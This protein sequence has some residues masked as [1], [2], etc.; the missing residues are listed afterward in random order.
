MKILL[1]YPEYPD[2][3]WSFKY[4]LKFVAKKAAFPPL[5]LLT[6]AALLPDSWEKKL[7]D[8]NVEELRDEHI[9]WADLVFLGAMLVQSKSAAEIISRCRHFGKKIV[10]GGPLFTTQHQNYPDIDHF[11]LNEAE[12]TLPQ[13]LS[14]LA[15]G[16][17]RR[18]YTADLKPDITR[19][20][21][22]LWD[23][24]DMKNYAT[25]LIQ[26]SRG[27]PFNCE[28]C[29]I[30]IMNGRIPRTKTPEQLVLEFQS[31]YDAGWR[32]SVFIVDDNFIGNKMKVKQLLP[33]LADW[34]KKHRYPFTL[35]TEASVDLANDE[36]LMQLMSKANF[37]K[38]FVGVETPNKESLK[39]CGKQQNTSSNLSEAVDIIHRHGMQ[40][41]GGFIVGFD[42]DP[43]NIFDMQITFI[44]QVGIVTAMVGLL[45]A[46]PQTRL[47][48]RLKAEG[49]LL[50][51]ASG[52]NTDGFLNFQPIMDRELLLDGYRKLLANLYSQ[53]QYYQR[54][55]TFLK[56][57]RPT[58]KARVTGDDLLALL[59]SIWQLG[60][61]SKA[62]F[63][64]WKLILKTMLFKRKAVPMAVELAII[65][66]HFEQILHRLEIT[67]KI[68][69]KES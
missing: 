67:R 59:R 43:E 4:A 10:A 12:I 50:G 25:M 18:L 20:P 15:A 6:V 33:V 2:T 55:N 56:N 53:K 9:A 11:V 39:E 46:L 30:V 64:Y 28:F 31:L 68:E 54:I 45:T 40:V 3:F 7:V 26:Y 17:P 14:D 27:C 23:L 49:R 51:D 62:R 1:V 65:G 21:I 63:H 60:I 38:V 34:Q 66:Q 69:Y 48:H 42:N 35:L 5:G 13:F 41:M 8:T 47:W 57:Y 16:H 32:K 22:P 29:D 19:T 58:V 44:Q 37:F 52:E 36:E 24:I 61:K